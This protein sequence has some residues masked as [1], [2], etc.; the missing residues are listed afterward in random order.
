MAV[1]DRLY[2]VCI[3]LEPKKKNL[4]SHIVNN[5]T[6]IDFQYFVQWKKTLST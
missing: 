1:V 2:T 6:C 3:M 4:A 5:C